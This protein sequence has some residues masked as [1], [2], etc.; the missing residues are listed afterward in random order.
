MATINGTT[1]N[2]TLTSGNAADTLNGLGG[3]D[4]LNGGG[5]NDRLFGGDGT[6]TLIGGNG[7]DSLDGGAGID[8]ADYSASGSAVTVNLVTGSG[9]GGDAAGDTLTGVENVIGSGQNDSLTGDAGANALS[10]GAGNDTLIG[11]AGADTLSGGAGTDRVD[12]AG[13]TAG[14]T[15]NL[16]AGLGAGGDA[17]GDVLSGIEDL[18]GS[19]LADSLTG[20]AAA[21]QIF[22]GSGA[23]SLIGGTGNDSLYGGNDNDVLNGGAGSD[24]VEGGSGVDT[25]DYGTSVAGVAVNLQNGSASGG[26]AAGDTL[27]GVENLTGTRFADTLTGDGNANVLTG[28]SGNDVLNAGNGSDTLAGGAGADTLYGGEGMDFLDYSA[29]GAGVSINLATGAA[30]GGDATGDVLAG[31]DG[32]F[33]S[34]FNDTLT[35]FDNQGLVGDVYWNE[36]YGAAGNDSISLGDGEDFGYGGADNDTVLGGGGNDVVEGGDGNDSLF[37]GTGNDTVAGDAGNDVLDGGDG[38]DKAS[39]GTGN[40]S[41]TG[42]AGNDSLD[43]GDGADSLFGGADA[44]TLSGGVGDDV[45][46]GGDGNDQTFGGTGNDALTGG[47]GNDSLDGGDGADTL[48]G[49]LGGDVLYGAAGSDTVDAG[50]G[51]DSLFGGVDGDWLSGGLGN[52]TLYGGSGNDYLTGGDGADLLVGG[53]GSDTVIGRAGDIID[54]EESDGDTDVLDLSGAGN[55]RVRRDPLNP[56]NGRVDFYTDAG[57]FLGSLTYTNIETV[58]ACFTPGTMIDTHSGPRAVET[59]A[60]GDTVLTRDRGYQTL[61]WVGRKTLEPA[62]LRRNMALQPILI[63]RGA[64]GPDSPQRDTMVSRQHRVLVQDGRCELLFGEPE[65]FVRALHLLDLP[66]VLAAVLPTVTYLHLMFDRHEVIR[67]DGTWSESFQP[68]PRSL[69]GLDDD[70]QAEVVAVF[71]TLDQPVTDTTY[72]AARLTL[73]AHEARVLLAHSRRTTVPRPVPRRL[74]RAG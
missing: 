16:V 51:A 5:G 9:S 57:V 73:K 58:I 30:S 3:D 55:F 43:G 22:G 35:G 36:I 20:D 64:L 44:D 11:G 63:R 38:N 56:E 14:V 26:D 23:D 7:N 48:S 12:Y 27:T 62:D 25:A 72:A 67:A 29:S 10:G 2:D 68:G 15:V 46:D 13:S 50:D 33:G 52:D 70:Q 4:L 60:A 21:N 34:A 1:G 49:G 31:A 37:G 28:A 42:G 19:G 65:V 53:D 41:V 32:I 71:P 18:V 61:R 47:A 54:G 45:L 40:D 66:D 39:G 69:G 6:D 74:A 17:A 8:T 24:R 59:L